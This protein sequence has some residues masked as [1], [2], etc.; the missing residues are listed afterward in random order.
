MNRF[1]G[2]STKPNRFMGI[3]I[4]DNSTA[5]IIK[6]TILGIPKAVKDVY[7][8][9]FKPVPGI[10]KD[11]A[12]GV[13]RTIAG[14]GTSAG[15]QVFKNINE[16]RASPLLPPVF[17]KPTPTPAPIPLP[18]EQ[19]IDTNQNKVSK[20]VFGGKPVNTVPKMIANTEEFLKPYIGDKA[21]SFAA[22]PLV[23][24]SIGL[25]LSGFGGKV[26]VKTLG[27]I[28]EQFFKNMAKEK[29]PQIIESTLKKI[30]LDEANAK[31]LAPRFAGVKTADEAKATLSEY[32]IPKPSETPSTQR[33]F[34]ERKKMPINDY[35]YAL[36]NKGIDT[37]YHNTS[38]QSARS[39]I[40]AYTE[41]RGLNVSTTPELALGQGGKGVTIEFDTKR[42][43]GNKINKPGADFIAATQG[44]YPEYEISKAPSK[45]TKD[46]KSV[47]FDAP[48]SKIG[49][50]NFFGNR[51]DWKIT[52]EIL[53][54]GK[55]K[56]TNPLHSPSTQRLFPE[57]TVPTPVAPVQSTLPIPVRRRCLNDCHFDR[58]FVSSVRPTRLGSILIGFS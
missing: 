53:P 43:E 29:S 14:V 42:L 35:P 9:I 21:S 55:V 32:G 57:R 49:E 8:P 52:K 13:A 22:L 44:K 41:N 31:A 5:G 3:S 7:A 11:S 34:P 47:T 45:L 1:T 39:T 33:L 58:G 4:P 26:G 18:F 50:R 38:P 19:S 30:G 36:S 28:P 24:G 2:L 54:N 27:E 48:L 23:I 12:Q 15:N 51:E 16:T 10:I 20:V 6:N 56:Y 40:F 17:A 25:D 46:V 37:V